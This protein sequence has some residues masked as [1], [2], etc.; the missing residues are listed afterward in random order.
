[1]TKHTNKQQQLKQLETQMV[2]LTESNRTYKR[3]NLEGG[4][5]YNPN[6][7]KIEELTKEITTLTTEIKT[8][9]LSGES[10]VTEYSLLVAGKFSQM[11]LAQQ[12]CTAR[13]YTVSDLIAAATKNGLRK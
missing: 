10:L 2:T 7:I 11:N 3:V 13:G 6:E 5:G 4:G 9:K 12:H 8:E 1:M